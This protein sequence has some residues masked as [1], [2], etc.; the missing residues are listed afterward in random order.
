MPVWVF[1][2]ILKTVAFN[3]PLLPANG[4]YMGLNLGVFWRIVMYMGTDFRAGQSDD[5]TG[6]FREGVEEDPRSTFN[7][8][9]GFP[10]TEDLYQ[11][12]LFKK[13]SSTLSIFPEKIW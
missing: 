6:V 10:G 9:K 3:G 12:G 7:K 1:L 8:N 4:H 11:P 5:F 13:S 2:L